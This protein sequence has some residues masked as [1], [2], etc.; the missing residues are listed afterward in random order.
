M[1]V[2]GFLQQLLH[3]SGLEGHIGVMMSVVALFV[4]NDFPAGALE[5]TSPAPPARFCQFDQ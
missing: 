3:L 4:F 2:D 1:L 5:T